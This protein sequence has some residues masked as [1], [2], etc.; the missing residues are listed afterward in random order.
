MSESQYV[1]N[2]CQIYVCSTLHLASWRRMVRGTSSNVAV[3]RSGEQISASSQQRRR[4]GGRIL[5]SESRPGK[6]SR[7]HVSGN[8][9]GKVHL[10]FWLS[11]SPISPYFHPKNLPIPPKVYLLKVQGTKSKASIDF[12][13]PL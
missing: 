12:H 13:C 6:L 5:V 2:L 10:N 11:G 3:W 1:H 4:P 8:F 7:V 9:Q